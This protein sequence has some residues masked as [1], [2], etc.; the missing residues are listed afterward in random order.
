[1]DN[2]SAEEE[3]ITLRMR[4]N[5]F[6]NSLKKLAQCFLNSASELSISWMEPQ[7]I[8]RLLGLAQGIESLKSLEGNEGE[9][10]AAFLK[11]II[12]IIQNI[13]VP[14]QTNKTQ[15]NE[16]RGKILK[17][18]KTLEDQIKDFLPVVIEIDTKRKK[19]DYETFG[20]LMQKLV[21]ASQ[22]K[23]HLILREQ[24]K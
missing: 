11:N 10:F 15:D 24:E 4:L 5:S 9:I 17:I 1:M 23:R 19:E 14:K 12:D 7:V 6:A 13:T 20:G 18:L 16:E 2:K 22:E 21:D 3:K 8:G